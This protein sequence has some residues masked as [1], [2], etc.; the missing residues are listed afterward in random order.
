MSSSQPTSP[1]SNSLPTPVGAVGGM[2]NGVGGMHSEGHSPMDQDSVAHTRKR[3][4]VQYYDI[5]CCLECEVKDA[6]I[7]T[8]RRRIQVMEEVVA[9]LNQKMNSL[10]QNSNMLFSQMVMP[11]IVSQ[12]MIPTTVKVCAYICLAADGSCCDLHGPFSLL[13]FYF[14][15]T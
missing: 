15:V 4:K 6:E 8:L 14:R 10:Q 7:K 13:L 12:V 3:A 2:S 11:P 5:N 1:L 9:L